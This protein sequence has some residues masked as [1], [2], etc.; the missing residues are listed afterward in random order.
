M[1]ERNFAK[2]SVFTIDTGY[3]CKYLEDSPTGLSVSCSTASPSWL[4]ARQLYR[5]KLEA[6]TEASTRE[7]R[8]TLPWG[9]TLSAGQIVAPSQ[10]TRASN[11]GY[12]RYEK[13]SQSRRRPIL[14]T[15]PG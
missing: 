2:C 3:L 13:I 5:P 4:R 11:E 1:T 12:P 14:G 8:I 6:V 15:S 7:L 9:H 10:W